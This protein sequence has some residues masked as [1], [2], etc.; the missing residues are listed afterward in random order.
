[1]IMKRITSII[2]IVLGI[3]VVS[4]SSCSSSQTFTVQGVPGT[5]ITNPQGQQIAVIDNSGQAKVELKRK[6]GYMH[7]LQAQ[8]PGSN[9]QVPFALD[10]KNNSGRA[11]RRG[12]GRAIMIAGA[13]VELGGCLTMISGGDAAT[14][15]AA[16]MVF[17]GCALAG[18]G[19]GMGAANTPIN[20][21]YDY[22][23]TQKTNNDIFK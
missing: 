5:F 12:A 3:T 18:L 13:V 16:A 23:K 7:Y 17:G 20:Y 11:V 10:Y 14:N 4:L 6:G 8:A 15:S 1:M 19:F 22:Q 9:L 2:M 21:D